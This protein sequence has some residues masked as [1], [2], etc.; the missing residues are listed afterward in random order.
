MPIP[1]DEQIAL[2][3]RRCERIISEQE[4]RTKL[5]RSAATG[6]PLRVKLGMDPTAPDVT[7]GHCVPLKVVRQ[8]QNLGHKAVLIIGD[9]TARVGDPTGRNATRKVLSGEEID[10]NAKTYVAQVA[11]ILRMDE[12]HLE[13]RYNGEW[14]GKMG[15]VDIIKLAARKSVAQ[16]LTREDF[17]KR[18]AE[19]VDIR[20]HEILY[21]LL[22]GWD[23]VMI[24]ADIEMGGSDQ[25]FNNLVGREFQKEEGKDGQCVFVTPLLVGTDGVKKMSKSLGNYVGVTDPAGGAGGMFGKIMSLPDGLM[26]SYYTLLT[27][28]PTSEFE[29][30][31]ATNPRDAKVRLAK[32]LITWLHDASAADQAEKDFMTATHGGVPSDIPELPVPAGPQSI[33]GLLVA[34]KIVGTNSEAIRKIREG[35]VKL[36][37]EKITDTKAAAEVT[38]PRVLQMGSKKFV[39]LTPA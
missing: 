38:A 36:D 37:G 21:P 24:D 28:L 25:L 15:L 12:A 19:G 31:I 35:A 39:R 32:H 5:Q 4:L 27:D 8:F 20:L 23:S 14:L 6:K 18:Y 16:V 33:V 2:L 10:A 3:S 30:L 22:Q 34:A 13:V 9:Y 7:L 29:P 1:I 17:A 26:N 11:K